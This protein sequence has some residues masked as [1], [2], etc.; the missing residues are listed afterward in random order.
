M[1]FGD[2]GKDEEECECILKKLDDFVNIT[3]QTIQVGTISAIDDFHH[4]SYG[5]YMLVF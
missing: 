2:K 3:A 5:Y 1:D 4:G